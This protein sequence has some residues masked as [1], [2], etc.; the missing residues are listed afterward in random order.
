MIMTLK[1]A[2][3]SFLNEPVLIDNGADHWSASNLIDELSY[4]DL[5]QKVYSCEDYIATLDDQG[6]HIS[7]PLMTIVHLSENPYFVIHEPN[8]YRVK[9]MID[10]ESDRYRR[11][12]GQSL[13]QYKQAAYR[14]KSSLNAKWHTLRILSA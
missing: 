14:R 11:I 9:L 7:P 13:Y 10:E 2:L 12:H 4:E 1:E 5:T 6:Y 8:G 3:E